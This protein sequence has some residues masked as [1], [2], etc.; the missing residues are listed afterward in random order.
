MSFSSQV[1]EELNS[2]AIK[3]NCCKKAWLFG[4]C[5]SAE[6]IDGNIHITLADE[7]T[8]EKLLFLLKAI[9]NVNPDISQIKKG[10]F[11]AFRLTFANR[12]LSD[13][14]NIIDELGASAYQ[15]DKERIFACPAC[16]T[17]F[18]RAAFCCAGSVSDPQ[19]SYTLEIRSTNEQ[20]AKFI[21]SIICDCGLE[22][23]H[24]TERKNAVG[25]FYRN[26]SA[27]EDILTA[28]GGSRSLFKFFDVFV[29]KDLRNSENRA[30]NCVAR[31]ISKSVEAAA[32][33]ISAIEAL[34]ANGMFDDFSDDIKHTADLRIDNPDISLTELAAMHKPPISK[35]GLNHR[36]TKIVEEAK[37]KK[38]I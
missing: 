4:T 34:I 28:C 21:E 11:S 25:L 12:K 26:E 15:A 23:P 5:I 36:L 20:R 16:R 22:S 35:S 14:L 6:H 8:K 31:N 19:K 30:T 29:E 1:K 24:R 3:N 18:L 32:L 7:S 38:L 27:I 9:Y 33:Q 13:F 17:A 37:K 2:L 10:C